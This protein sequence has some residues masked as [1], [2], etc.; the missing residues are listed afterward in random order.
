M[1]KLSSN[2]LN[3][4]SNVIREKINESKGKKISSKLEKDVDF[5]KLEVINKELRDLSSKMS[6]KNNEFNELTS[7]L[8]VKYGKDEDI[9][10]NNVKGKIKVNFN[11]YNNGVYN[12]LVL[13]SIGKEVD[14]ESIVNKLVEKYSG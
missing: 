8:K 9:Y 10:F 13:L 1:K 14:I 4:L 6:E 3:V 12:D 2:E 5:K 11:N 7:K